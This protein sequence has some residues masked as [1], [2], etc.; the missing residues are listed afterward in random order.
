M[1]AL[2]INL[3]PS[4]RHLRQFGVIWLVFFGVLAALTWR[5][6]GSWPASAAIGA[7]ALVPP[8][9]GMIWLPVLRWC[10]ISLTILTFP[11][12][13]VLSHVV[14]AIVFYLVITP[15]GLI[16]RAAGRDPMSR[17]LDRAARSYWVRREPPADLKR[18][19]R[20]F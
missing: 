7:V 12:G 4:P 5:R 18:Y 17:P 16:M 15:I 10:Y 2:S 6:S 9:A 11:I 3:N 8:L 20:Q 13:F 14:L 19:F 1:S